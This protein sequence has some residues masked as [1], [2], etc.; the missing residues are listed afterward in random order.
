MK[1]LCICIYNFLANKMVETKTGIQKFHQ[2]KLPSWNTLETC[3]F[4][5]R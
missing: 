5:H 1:I 4:S 3:V 2:S